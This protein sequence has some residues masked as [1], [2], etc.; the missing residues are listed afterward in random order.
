[1]DDARDKSGR[2]VVCVLVSSIESVCS[3]LE[4]WYDWCHDESQWN[5]LDCSNG[6]TGSMEQGHLDCWN[7]SVRSC[8]I[9]CDKQCDA[10]FKRHHMEPRGWID[11][12][13]YPENCMVARTWIYVRVCLGW[14]VYESRWC[15]VDADVNPL[16]K[17]SAKHCVV[18]WA[19]SVCRMPD[20]ELKLGHFYEQRCG[21]LDDDESGIFLL[22]GI[23]VG[24]P[25]R[26][27][28]HLV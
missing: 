28:C 9:G 21:H 11:A 18:S 27:V 2:V 23:D 8:C 26:H 15:Y 20:H 4:E 22:E 16:D 25:A 6:S 3:R 5:W 17:S 24:L 13:V 1:M 10:K 12:A 19:W 7:R 14:N